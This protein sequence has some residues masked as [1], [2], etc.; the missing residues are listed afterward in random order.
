MGETPASPAPHPLRHR[1]VTAVDRCLERR[2][3]G[4]RGEDAGSAFP[5]REVEPLKTLPR[6]GFI[7][8]VVIALRVG[9][10][11]EVWPPP[12]AGMVLR[13][14]SSGGKTCYGRTR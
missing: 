11:G 6:V 9:D 14:H 12:L 4:H 2:G 5:A 1:E 10:V 3:S 7:L 13:V 8:A